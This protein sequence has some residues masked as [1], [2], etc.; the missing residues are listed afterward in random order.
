M[1]NSPLP[2]RPYW[3]TLLLLFSISATFAEINILPGYMDYTAFAERVRKLDEQATVTLDSLGTTLEGRELFVLR[4]AASDVTTGPAILIIGGVDSQYPAGTELALRMAEGLAADAE[5]LKSATVHVIPL[6]NPDGH[7]HARSSPG[8][9]RWGNA[10]KTDDDR[11]GRF[12]EDPPEDLDGDGWIGVMRVHRLGGRLRPD[13]EDAR[14]STAGDPAK[15]KPGSFDEYIEGI[16][17]DHDESWNEDAG[18]GVEFNRNFA[19][20]YSP[21]E[22]QT[23]PNP[24]S[25]I[26]SRAI[27]DYCFAH[28]EIQIAYVLGPQDNLV[29][30]WKVESGAPARVPTSIAADDGPYFARLS[31]MYQEKTNLKEVATNGTA[32]GAFLHWTYFHWGR[33]VLGSTGWSPPK[34]APPA[35]TGGADA[36]SAEGTPDQ[37]SEAGNAAVGGDERSAPRPDV[38]GGRGEIPPE[39]RRGMMGRRRRFSGGGGGPTERS[40]AAVSASPEEIASQRQALKWMDE[41]HLDGFINWH[42][43][44]H[45]DFPGLKV[46]IGGMKP[47]WRSNPPATELDGLAK[48]QV[49]FVQELA[50]LLPRLEIS[51]PTISN[52]GGGLYRVEVE[53]H[54]VGYL[55]TSTE[56]GATGGLTY[57][58][59]IELKVPDPI[60]LAVPGALRSRER[61]LEAGTSRQRTWVLRVADTAQHQLTIRVGSVMTGF[62]ERP[63]ELNP[64]PAGA[65]P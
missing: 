34:P 2:F 9:I 6:A 13:D 19:F 18:D 24:V 12:A 21:F 48:S 16:D 5:L 30:A 1:R 58:V 39:V 53:F 42:D 45:P 56:F 52:L 46:E 11:D 49:V 50:K 7:A 20:K 47:L 44:P 60:E 14:L 57:P 36:K 8:R 3:V 32:N 65:T 62:T 31:E 43:Y 29:Q 55:P 25:E 54:N 37:K 51:P 63:F 15:Q 27:A 35:E 26:E 40:S 61:R 10:T 64:S 59:Q 22:K 23:G 41:Q 33:W 4:L 38:A 17:N 28:P